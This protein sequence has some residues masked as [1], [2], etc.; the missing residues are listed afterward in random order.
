MATVDYPKGL[1]EELAKRLYGSVT[2]TWSS[3]AFTF[4][5]ARSEC[6]EWLERG[7]IGIDS[8]QDYTAGA[9]PQLVNVVRRG[10]DNKVRVF[11]FSDGS[12]LE[13]ET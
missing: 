12:V 2:V 5:P 9:W 7:A 8:S 1:S 6:R 13:Q 11:Q 10:T 4:D 3:A